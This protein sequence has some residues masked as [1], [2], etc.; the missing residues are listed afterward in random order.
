MFPRV[1]GPLPYP[2]ED[3]VSDSLVFVTA[4]GERYHATE[5]CPRYQSGRQGN[6]ALGNQAHPV[7]WMSRQQAAARK[8]RCPECVTDR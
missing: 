6:D 3:A 2:K 7:Q 1:T 5:D 4:G 8:D